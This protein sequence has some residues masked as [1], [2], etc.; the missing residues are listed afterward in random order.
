MSQLE[1]HY[2]SLGDRVPAELREQL[3]ELEK[4]LAAG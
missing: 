1:G 3:T 4:R 2:R